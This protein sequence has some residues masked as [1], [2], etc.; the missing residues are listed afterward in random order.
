MNISQFPLTIAKLD[1]TRSLERFIAGA[2]A[3]L[4]QGEVIKAEFNRLKEDANRVCEDAWKNRESGNIWECHGP[5]C[6]ASV[7]MWQAIGSTYAHNMP[8]VLK[9]L[10]NAKKIDQDAPVIIAAKA[11]VTELVV[12]ADMLA[13]IKATIVTKKSA[14]IQKEQAAHELLKAQ[15]NHADTQRVATFL[16]DFT[17]NV[18]ADLI[19][20]R[21]AYLTTVITQVIDRVT[22]EEMNYTTARRTFTGM[23]QIF[24]ITHLM[25]NKK[26]NAP[27]VP[28]SADEVEAYILKQAEA[29]AD[30]VVAFFIARTTTKIAPILSRKADLATVAFADDRYSLHQGLIEA[31][32]VLTFNDGSCFSLNS[33][34]EYSTSVN[35]TPFL[36]FPSRFTNAFTADGARVANVCEEAMYTQ[37]LSIR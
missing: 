25:T 32:L 34:V 33:K 35:G 14:Q 24:A 37:W 15:T 30:E 8:G 26:W 36:R 13:A 9:K 31:V 6:N 3:A 10:S 4:E 20:A 12:I 5:V 28:V 23:D 22:A 19:E 29:A 11:L 27:L 1:S 16:T 17:Q 21:V 7:Y 18:R 2:N